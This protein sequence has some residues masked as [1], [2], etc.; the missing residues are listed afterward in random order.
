MPSQEL[1]VGY[2]SDLTIRHAANMR[3]LIA[4]GL[5]PRADIVLDIN[6]DAAVDLSFVQLVASARRHAASVGSAI[7]LAQPAGPK[8][9]EVLDRGGFVEGAA[10]EDLSFWFH[11]ENAQ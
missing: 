11:V 9:R 4:G 1:R 7:S 3:E 10:T 8:L 2:E 6:P 5:V